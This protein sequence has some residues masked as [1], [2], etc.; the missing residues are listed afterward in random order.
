M[1][2]RFNFHNL[3]LGIK[4]LFPLLALVLALILVS[5]MAV[6]STHRV[7]NKLIDNLYN[8]ANQSSDLLLNADRDLYEA[9]TAQMNMENADS[10]DDYDL[11]SKSYH[12]N[13]K[14][15][16]DRMHKAQS[17]LDKNK[18][19]FK[20]YKDKDTKK[21]SDQLFDLF[22]KNFKEYTALIDPDTGII[23]DKGE[24]NKTFDSARESIRG[25]ENIL[26]SYSQDIIKDSKD[27]VNATQAVTIVVSLVALALSLFLG[28]LIING[29]IRRTR[30]T[31]NFIRK[32][33]N[34]DMKYDTSYEKYFTE[35]DEFAEIINA[36]A[37]ARREFRSIIA[38]VVK[39][40]AALNEAISHTN[41][42][43]SHLEDGIEDIS[44]TTEQLSAGMQETAASA[45]EMNA[46]SLQIE[47]AVENIAEKAQEGAIAAENINNKANELGIS[48]KNTYDNA[49]ELF[50]DVKTRLE[51]SL[52]ESKAVKKING[53]ADAIL[54]ITSQTNILS[55]NAAIEAAR[56]GEAGKGFAVVADEIR[57]LAEDSKKAVAEIQSVTQTVTRSVDHLTV[58]SHE[59]LD[60]MSKNVNQD[61]LTM[62]DASKQYN[63]DADHI[64]GVITDLSA[65]SEELLA[66]IH[67]MIK[68]INEV[69][70]ASN[71]GAAGTNTIAQSSSLIVAKANDVLNSINSTKAGANSLQQMVSKFNV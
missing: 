34:F 35:K 61:Y 8:E 4:L 30:L 14:E 47:K 10:T 27:S 40:A 25:I 33:A 60:F 24:M 50:L 5:T 22:Y 18:D 32:T 36:E 42:S 9:L 6:T 31:V 37:T 66:S 59:I 45:L 65:T 62:L 13:V 53:L 49:L 23:S 39:E 52:E 70:H 7:S 55:L 63:Q 20:K 64:Y 58:S 51:Q 69:T 56:A 38:N 17:I 3:S 43:M 2:K 57:K 11:A 16:L 48:F 19:T 26:T 68:A 67:N 28:Y 15:T 12:D 46:A 21:T 41:T 29:V 54:Q 44:A 1:F 71:E